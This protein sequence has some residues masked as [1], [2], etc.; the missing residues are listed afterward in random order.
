MWY[1]AGALFLQ[2]SALWLIRGFTLCCFLYIVTC[3][4]M[5]QE[6]DNWTTLSSDV[7]EIFQTGDVDEVWCL[8]L[9]VDFVHKLKIFVWWTIFFARCFSEWK[10]LESRSS[11]G[12]C[13]NICPNDGRE[14]FQYNADSLIRLFSVSDS[15]KVNWDA[16]KS[17]EFSIYSLCSVA[18]VKIL[19]PRPND[20]SLL[21]KHLR[22]AL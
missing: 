12:I 1:S 8:K 16:E 6:A 15:R 21:V 7:D 19:K 13:Y 20:Q 5:L 18:L 3:L 4:Y 2:I 17:C 11:A 10:M 9:A 14:S 22:Y